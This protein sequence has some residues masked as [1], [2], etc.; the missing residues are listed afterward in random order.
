V[1]W[2]GA[3]IAGGVQ[4]SSQEDRTRE[5]LGVEK[6]PKFKGKESRVCDSRL[7]FDITIPYEVLF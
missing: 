6:V 5:D 4:M 7:G 3:T 2:I 1:A